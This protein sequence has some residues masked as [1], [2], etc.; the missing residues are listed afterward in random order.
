MSAKLIKQHMAELEDAFGHR[1][2]IEMLGELDGM[3]CLNQSPEWLEAITRKRDM[4]QGQLN[5]WANHYAQ[6]RD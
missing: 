2:T 3:L 6:R 1:G 5:E 4:L